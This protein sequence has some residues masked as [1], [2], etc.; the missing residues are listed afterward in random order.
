MST[1]DRKIDGSIL[2][3]VSEC[4]N[5]VSRVNKPKRPGLPESI[6]AVDWLP[7]MAINKG[8]KLM[9]MAP[10]HVL[11]KKR[12]ILGS[13]LYIFSFFNGLQEK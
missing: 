7:W 12:M 9:L 4:I 3:S 11:Q 6:Q 8:G 10:S 2:G 1:L 13:L 5:I